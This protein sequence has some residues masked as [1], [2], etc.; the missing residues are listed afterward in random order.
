MKRF[1]L[2]AMMT[3]LFLS[4]SQSVWAFSDTKNDPNEAKIAELQKQGILSGSGKDGAF[5]P[6]GKLT[7]AAGITMIVKGLGLNIDNIRF[8]KEPKVS[9]YFSKMK[10]N[11]WYAQTFII[12]S[13]NGL[14]IPRDTDPSAV[15]TREQFAHHLMKGVLKKGDFA[16]IDL[17][18]ML[19]DEKDVTPA[20]MDSIQKLL[21]TKIAQL[22]SSQKFYP[23]KSITR[24]DAAGW[25]YGAIQFVKNTP[26]IPP[27]EEPEPFPLFDLKVTVKSVNADVNEVTVSAQAPNP[28]YGLRIGSISFEGNQ[29]IIQ[30]V[31]VYPDKDKMYP[32]V[33]TEV[34]AVTYVASG[35]KPVLADTGASSGGSTGI[36]GGGHT[37]VNPAGPDAA[38]SN[39]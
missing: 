9:D 19:K 39:Q 13:L 1:V 12:A 33:I 27:V 37:A 36:I 38:A 15:M 34:K 22:D 6:N 35:L 20:Y 4:I 30:V 32:Q 31:P 28:G 10:D 23:K 24:S 25:L 14:D 3:V 18:I 5:Q 11:A 29:A 16:F 8:I 21:I 26:P 2:L 7:Y 17:Y